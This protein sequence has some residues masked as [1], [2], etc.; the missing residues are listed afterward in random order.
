MHTPVSPLMNLGVR[1]FAVIDMGAP[2]C[3]LG[4]AKLGRLC[5][6]AVTTGSGIVPR[7]DPNGASGIGVLRVSNRLFDENEYIVLL[8]RVKTSTSPTGLTQPSLCGTFRDRPH[9][10]AQQHTFL[11]DR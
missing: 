11:G 7:K 10:V 8:V 2:D 3:S 9:D 4:G 1:I 5:E 6:A